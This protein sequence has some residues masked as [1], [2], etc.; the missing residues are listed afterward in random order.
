M[1]IGFLPRMSKCFLIFWEIPP[2]LTEKTMRKRSP[3]HSLASFPDQ[4]FD[5]AS[6]KDPSLG[7]K[8][9]SCH[10]DQGEQVHLPGRFGLID[11]RLVGVLP[12]EILLKDSLVAPPLTDSLKKVLA[13]PACRLPGPIKVTGDAPS[14]EEE[15]VR[16]AQGFDL[17][18]A[19]FGQRGD[20]LLK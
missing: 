19:E 9:F 1:D 4:P 2:P 20:V 15:V 3:E 17:Q 18:G 16:E 10:R 5:G 7:G 6:E 13:D 8:L 12:A 11:G 14:A